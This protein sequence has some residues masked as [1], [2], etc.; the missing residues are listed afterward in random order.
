M[1]VID[2]VQPYVVVT[3]AAVVEAAQC[4]A[5]RS[6]RGGGS[7]TRATQAP[8]G[9]GGA[10]L[11]CVMAHRNESDVFLE[12]RARVCVSVY[13]C[14]RLC[15]VRM[16]LCCCLCVRRCTSVYVYVCMCLCCVLRAT[17][18]FAAAFART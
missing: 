17:T 11:A 18:H 6:L 14:A 7:G 9:D 12:V 4:S 8:G 3:S 5:A 13:V 16:Y 2:L 10:A 15:I 1:Q